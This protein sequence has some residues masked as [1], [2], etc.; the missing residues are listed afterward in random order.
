MIYHIGKTAIW[1]AIAFGLAACP[2][3]RFRHEKY[4]CKSVSFDLESVIVNDTDIG[5][6]V[7]IIGY[8]NDR[9]AIIKSIS[10]NHIEIEDSSIKLELDRN[11]GSVRISRGTRFAHLACKRSI[12]I[13]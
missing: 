12:F 7:K 1:F 6:K 5:G 8:G 11:D 4:V 9:T 13:M 2:A 10:D 3:E